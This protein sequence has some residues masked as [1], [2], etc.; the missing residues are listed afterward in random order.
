MDI[1]VINLGRKFKKMQY[2]FLG[3][4]DILALL[5]ARYYINLIVFD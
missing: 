3:E 1:Y 5:R 2:L 4:S